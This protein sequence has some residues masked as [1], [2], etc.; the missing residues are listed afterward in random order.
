MYGMVKDAQLIAA[1]K[2]M[3][4]M[5]LECTDKP[6]DKINDIFAY[7][8]PQFLQRSENLELIAKEK[9]EAQRALELLQ[10]GKQ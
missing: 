4:Q 3:S 6:Y 5:C 2:K 7:N 8:M 1:Q 9:F 10:S